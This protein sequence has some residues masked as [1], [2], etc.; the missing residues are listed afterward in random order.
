MIDIL[1]LQLLIPVA[2]LWWQWRSRALT[3]GECA[4]RAAAVLG[5]LMAIALAGLWLLLPWW[6]PF[7]YLLVAGGLTWTH[8]RRPLSEARL[9][10]SQ[11]TTR[12]SAACPS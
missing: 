3:R 5:Y 2:L 10:V 7:V 11:P 9:T 12:S 8:C 6:T 1:G 4:V